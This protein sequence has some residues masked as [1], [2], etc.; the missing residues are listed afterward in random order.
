MFFIFSENVPASA[1]SPFYDSA[2]DLEGVMYSLPEFLPYIPHAKRDLDEM[3]GESPLNKLFSPSNINKIKSSD[4]ILTVAGNLEAPLSL[5][6]S[7]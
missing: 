7:Q 1:L 6:N 2:F 3:D 5:D 4:I